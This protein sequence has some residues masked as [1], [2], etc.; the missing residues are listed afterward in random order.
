[1][2]VRDGEA[3]RYDA[4]TPDDQCPMCHLLLYNPVTTTC[5]HTFCSRCMSHWADVSVTSQM[6]I[7]PLSD[8]PVDLTPSNVEAKCPMCRTLTSAHPATDL[9]SGLQDKYSAAYAQRRA[10]DGDEEELATVETITVYIGNKHS[11]VPAAPGSGNCH[12]WTFFVRP[13]RTDIIQAVRMNLHPTF[14]PPSVTRQDPPYEIRRLGW[15]YF[16]INA[17][18]VL[19]KGWAWL[20]NDAYGEE[21]RALPLDWTLDFEGEGS[22]GRCRLKVKRFVTEPAIEE[23]SEVVGLHS[24]DDEDDWEDD[25]EDE[26]ENIDLDE[27]IPLDETS[28]TLSTE[29]GDSG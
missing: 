29:T 14:R 19:K 10:D 28:S 22:M 25:D 6:A 26:D 1:M 5:N 2:E 27:G 13:S 8:I 4:V 17:L 21:K 24:T 18:V 12:D 7:V 23:E 15:G 16:A 11:L 9:A 3:S 20:S